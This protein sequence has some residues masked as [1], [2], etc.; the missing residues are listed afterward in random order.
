MI[1]DL[2]RDLSPWL[3]YLTALLLCGAAGAMAFLPLPQPAGAEIA[4]AETPQQP[5]SEAVVG[6]KKSK[7]LLFVGLGLLLVLI[8]VIIGFLAR[9]GLLQRISTM[10]DDHAAEIA[11]LQ[12]DHAA[13]MQQQE[14]QYEDRL[15]RQKDTYEGQIEALRERQQTQTQLTELQTNQR[16]RDMEDQIKETQELHDEEVEQFEEQIEELETQ[17]QELQLRLQMQGGGVFR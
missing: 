7:I 17:L 6:G 9:E 2:L 12:A 5:W 8:F 15:Q 11:R 1:V 14:T 4:D 3:S 13:A 10:E 16:I